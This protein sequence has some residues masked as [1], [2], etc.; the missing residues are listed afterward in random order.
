MPDVSKIGSTVPAAGAGR[1]A[2]LATIV[3]GAADG[4]GAATAS[5]FA[6]EGASVMV[7]DVNEEAGLALVDRLGG[8]A[9]F[10]HCD[11]SN[12]EHWREL[13]DA[14]VARF[15]CVDVLVNNAGIHVFSAIEDVE[16][17]VFRRMMDV[18]VLGTHLGM[19]S[20][21]PL[22]KQ[23]RKGSII[24][25]SSVDGMRGSTN[26]SSYAATKWAVRGMTKAVAMEAGPYGVRVNSVHPGAIITKMGNPEGRSPAELA[27]M[28][29]GIAMGRFGW[30]D[31]IARANVYLASDDASYVSGAELAVDGAW[32]AGIFMG[33]KPTM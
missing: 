28:A 11:V 10:V 18:N 9:H 4:I 1:L 16:T 23:A 2:G 20:V 21:L 13:V 30:P 31:E 3:T 12:E 14:T 26:M 27:D 24:N 29:P 19:K 5:A 33:A 7:A 17:S 6:G 32:V 25:V 15:G 8:R 22:M